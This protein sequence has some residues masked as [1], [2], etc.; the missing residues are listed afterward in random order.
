MSDSWEQKKY[1]MHRFQASAENAN[2]RIGH[3][4]L[5]IR[6]ELHHTITPTPASPVEAHELPLEMHPILRYL[7]IHFAS[8]NASVGLL[9]GRIDSL[10]DRIGSLDDR[11]AS[12]EN[13]ID[14][15]GGRVA[16]NTSNVYQ[17]AEQ[18]N[19]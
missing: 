5:R 12:L 18:G 11:I 1:S 17:S 13:R 6:P 19:Q 9:N 10:N 7:D 8:V 14:L 3:H 2:H 4:L 15:L 16:L